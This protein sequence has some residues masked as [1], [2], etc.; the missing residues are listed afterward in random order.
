MRFGPYVLDS[1]LAVGGTA[2]VYLAH[3]ADPNAPQTRVVVKRLLPDFLTDDEARTM[4]EREGEL[5]A[6]VRHENV[7]RVMAS[8]KSADGEPF[9][10]MEYVEGVDGYR[11]LRRLRQDARTLPIPI[12][13]HVAREV[14]VG[15]HVVHTAKDERGQP[16][17]IVHRD[18]TPSNVYLSK[19]GRVKLGDFGIARAAATRALNAQSAVL[20]GKFAYLAPEQVA[21][22]AFDHRADLFSAGSVLAEMIL[23]EP[24]FGGGGQLAVLLAIRDC[25]LDPLHAVRARMPPGLYDVMLR[26]LAR[27]PEDRFPDAQSFADALAPFVP[28]LV[29]AHAE[30]SEL[31]AVATRSISADTLA[32]VRDSAKLFS[33][34]AMDAPAEGLE[35]ERPTGEYTTMPSFVRTSR[36][37]Q[38]GPWT[39]ASLIEAI[40][41]GSV[42]RGDSVDYMGRGF[43][44][45]EEVAELARF[46]PPASQATREVASPTDADK[47]YDLSTVSA[48]D[49][50]LGVLETSETGVL[51]CE[52]ASPG[53]KGGVARKELYFLKGRLHH[54]ASSN[55]SE[56]LGEYLVRRGKIAREELDM[57]LAVLP[58]HGG[59]MGDTLISLGLVSAVDIFQAIRE[60]GRDRVADVFMWTQ[61]K[62]TFYAGQL[63]NHVEFPLDLDLAALVLAG[64]EAALPGEAAVER[65]RARLHATVGPGKRDRSGLLSVKWPPQ[66]AAVEAL[67][68]RPR[69]LSEL[70]SDATRGGKTTAGSVLRA[71]EILSAARVISVD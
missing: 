66:I 39:F 7:V 36:G 32:A 41:T 45:V 43:E 5:Q 70:L 25:R 67:A 22:E 71:I 44:L 47:S 17:S 53:E 65:Y 21:N 34:A 68:R 50:L 15:L 56:L 8:G 10:A 28:P 2:E 19:D 46:L 62:A 42:G 61:G 9:L 54:V 29:V 27:D 16:L 23:G 40:A 26:G 35:A 31:V 20:K 6:H 1:R 4:F 30:L 55:A 38:Y 57:A 24:L 64:M 63:A 14:L 18:V 69:R 52:R 51:I 12:A 33:A 58:R 37:E 13:A 3:A 49:V 59:R 48:L 60:Q 11:L